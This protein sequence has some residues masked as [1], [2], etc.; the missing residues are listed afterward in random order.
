MIN[1]NGSRLDIIRIGKKEDVAKKVYENCAIETI[2]EGMFVQIKKQSDAY[3]QKKDALY[4]SVTDVN[5]KQRW[6]RIKEIQEDW[7]NRCSGLE[8]LDY[9]VVKCATIIAGTC[10]GFLS[11]DYVKDLDFDYVIIDEAAKATTPELLVSIIKAKKIVLVGD[12]NQLPAYANQDLSPIIAEL[13]KKPQ[14]RLF[15]ILFKELPDLMYIF[16]N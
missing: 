9:Q 4:E 3:I 6:E 1:L 8:S 16:L 2:R 15:D 13:T 11:N 5:E 10:I 12:Q 14:Y 7:I